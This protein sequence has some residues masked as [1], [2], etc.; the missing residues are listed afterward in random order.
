MRIALSLLALFAI[1]VAAALLA[2]N[3]EGT[4]TVFLPPYRVDLSLNLVL[5]LML[6]MFLVLHLA[7]RA[8]SLLFGM[9]REARRW[10]I[11]H[12]E[13]TMFVAMVDSLTHLVAGRFI[14]A[15]KSAEMVL[16]QEGVLHRGGEKPIYGDRLRS[17]A[18]LL[19]AESAH[20]LQNREDREVHFRQA[21]SQ[22]NKRDAQETREGVQ[23]RAARWALDDRDATEALRWLE[24]LPL[25][26]AR[27]TVAMRLRLKAA[28]LGGQ[29]AAALETARLLAKH[30]AFSVAAGQSIVRGLVLELINASHDA[31]QLEKV[32]T[33]LDGVERGN[34]DITI[35]AAK[36][37]LTLG[38]NIEL[39]RVWLLPVWEQMLD[40]MAAIISL[41]LS[42]AD[43]LAKPQTLKGLTQDQC[44]GVI[45][46][47]ERGFAMD[48]DAPD[49]T[50]LTRIEG[51]Q[52]RFPGDPM[53]QYL[54]GITCMHLK[55]WGKAQQL[56]T[57][58]LSQL[59][60]PRLARSAWLSL[61]TLAEQR[62]DSAA[63]TQALQ[64]AL[65][66]G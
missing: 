57:Q 29:T 19:A 26:A 49:A 61:A 58:S 15:R 20:S 2:G 38:G 16:M 56:L 22:S 46:T 42:P 54:A 43:S 36:R 34:P 5:V 35:S 41:A 1:A 13:R 51:A 32:W 39:S 6:G 63:S 52:L 23:L 17:M 45:E 12:R 21:L 14:R 64:K 31:A 11:Q 47:L 48:T 60:S 65:S 66:I 55:L 37:L 18:H 9:P 33:A 27:R 7:L 25:G 30:R 8:L 44:V 3:N 50:W 59:R 24:E 62:G 10:R 53:L 28:R 40:A 4:I